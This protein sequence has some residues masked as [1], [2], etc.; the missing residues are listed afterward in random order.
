MPTEGHCKVS[1]GMVT[2]RAPSTAVQ[3]HQVSRRMQRELT[4]SSAQ[5]SG[6]PDSSMPEITAQT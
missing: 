1:W 2:C 4:G 5:R 6:I 3:T